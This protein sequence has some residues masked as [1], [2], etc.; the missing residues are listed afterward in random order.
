G[1]HRVQPGG[2]AD[3]GDDQPADLARLLGQR[4]ERAT[5]GEPAAAIVL[6]ALAFLAARALAILAAAIFATA[7]AA[8]G[9]LFG[10]AAAAGAFATGAVGCRAF[11]GHGLAIAA[12]ALAIALALVLAVGAR[13]TD[14]FA[15]VA[16]QAVPDPPALGRT[17]GTRGL[18]AT[19]LAR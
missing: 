16:R 9:V 7:R 8:L 15:I 18:A 4:A 17:D 13:F 5:D 19:A 14:R 3:F 1:A 12:L 2:G 11:L 10:L 6:P